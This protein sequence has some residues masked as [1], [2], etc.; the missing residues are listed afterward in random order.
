VNHNP[1]IAQSTLWVWTLDY[2]T[3][4]VIDLSHA[5][6]VGAEATTAIRQ[7][8]VIAAKRMI[9]RMMKRFARPKKCSIAKAR[10]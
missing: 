4:Y 2:A 10:L 5:I 3:K 6:I 8:E 7:A 1:I 9:E